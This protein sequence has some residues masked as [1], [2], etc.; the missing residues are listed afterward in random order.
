MCII[1]NNSA[2]SNDNYGRLQ[3]IVL[4]FKIATGTR[5]DFFEIHGQ[6]EEAS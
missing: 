4:L 2:I 1:N 6:F 3:G 5:K